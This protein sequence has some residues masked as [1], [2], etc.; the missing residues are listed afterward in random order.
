MKNYP[1]PSHRLHE[2]VKAAKCPQVGESLEFH[3][4]G[5]KGKKLDVRLDLVDGEFVGL[6]LFVHCGN[7]PKSPSEKSC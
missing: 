2:I 1:I 6:R 7:G 5:G 4:R 3:N